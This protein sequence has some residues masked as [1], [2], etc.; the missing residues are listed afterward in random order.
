MNIAIWT[1][2]RFLVLFVLACTT[3]PGA[4]KL[5]SAR[6]PLSGVKMELSG[7]RGPLAFKSGELNLKAGHLDGTFEGEVGSALKA[8]GQLH[9]PN[10][11]KPVADVEI[12]TPTARRSTAVFTFT[13]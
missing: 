1:P 7:M 10:I 2:S 13:S 6:V 9:V 8:K 12:S 5:W 4:L 3:Q 11:E